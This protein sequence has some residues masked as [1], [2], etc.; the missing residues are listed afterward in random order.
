M[1]SR[2]EHCNRVEARI[3]ANI[4]ADKMLKKYAGVVNEM[5]AEELV[6]EFISE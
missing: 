5:N 6:L 4:D 3:L 2:Y 1:Q